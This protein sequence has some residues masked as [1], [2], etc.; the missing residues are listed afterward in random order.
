MGR[1]VSGLEV[2]L[3]HQA[4]QQHVAG[5]VI[6]YG[7]TLD[8][9]EVDWTHSDLDDSLPPYSVRVRTGGHE[10][11]LRSEEW[12]GRTDEVQGRVF[13]WL[14]AHVDLNAAKLQTDPKRLAPEWLQAWHQV[15]PDG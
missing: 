3:A 2:Y 1:G 13:G 6:R 9:P 12:V 4:V 5:L 7:I 15:H 10:L 11:L 8:G 14:L